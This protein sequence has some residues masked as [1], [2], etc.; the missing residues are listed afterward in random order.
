MTSSHCLTPFLSS[1]HENISTTSTKISSCLFSKK[2]SDK[3]EID[4]S[5]SLS[6]SETSND[7]SIIQELDLSK[8]KVMQK[9]LK[10]SQS[11]TEI[12]QNEIQPTNYDK[13]LGK[14]PKK[15]GTLKKIDQSPRPKTEPTN[16]NKRPNKE[17]Y[18]TDEFCSS[19]PKKHIKGENGRIER[20]KDKEQNETAFEK[21]QE[22]EKI[23]IEW[24]T[25][26]QPK[27][28]RRRKERK[29][30]LHSEES[31]N[32]KKAQ[33][34]D[35]GGGKSFLQVVSIQDHNQPLISNIIIDK[36]SKH[37]QFD[38]LSDVSL[39]TGQSSPKSNAKKSSKSKLMTN[40]KPKQ[41][42]KN[43]KIKSPSIAPKNFN[44]EKDLLLNSDPFYELLKSPPINRVCFNLEN[45]NCMILEQ[46]SLS[47]SENQLNLFSQMQNELTMQTEHPNKQIDSYF[48]FSK[49]D[50][51]N[52][53]Q[54]TPLGITH[55]VAVP[56]FVLNTK[57]R[58]V[59]RRKPKQVW[60]P[61]L[62][63][64]EQLN[65][66]FRKVEIVIEQRIKNEEKA[67]EYLQKFNLNIDKLVENIKK[68]K[69]HYQ[70]C[71]GLEQRTLRNRKNL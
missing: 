6:S 24:S 48:D 14:G 66:Y 50:S 55:Q 67:I 61:E 15:K 70:N 57:L 13:E 47:P 9:L 12:F 42:A 40:G 62:M 25:S 44:Q 45:K 49:S 5:K 54:K 28:S 43:M 18:V 37:K 11:S 16:L 38:Q 23:H 7:L 58:N 71:F 20:P 46:K 26:K 32:E 31:I 33:E 10:S 34:L 21:N 4:A 41:V 3:N 52:I 69:P 56:N 60:S 17:I 2:S 68:N 29:K 59:K 22:K 53:V 30:N 63:N 35:N 64:E 39:S 27:S 36:S 51:N 19:N 8:V 65:E 1:T